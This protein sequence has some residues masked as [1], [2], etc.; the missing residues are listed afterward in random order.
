MK[1]LVSLEKKKF[2]KN[3]Y[4]EERDYVSSYDLVMELLDNS[5]CEQGDIKEMIEICAYCFSSFYKS[6]KYTLEADVIDAHNDWI[7]INY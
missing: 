4:V 2:L 3:E 5:Y 7:E 1:N 6:C